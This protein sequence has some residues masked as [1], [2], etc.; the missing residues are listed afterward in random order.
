MNETSRRKGRIRRFMKVGFDWEPNVTNGQQPSVRISVSGI[1]IN[2]P[3][4]MQLMRLQA[5]LVVVSIYPGSEINLSLN[6]E[7]I[8]G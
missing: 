2:I 1:S 5:T 4:W 3:F 7:Y 6:G 8:I